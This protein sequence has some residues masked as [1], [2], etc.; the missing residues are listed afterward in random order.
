MHRDPT[1]ARIGDT[2]VHYRRVLA[3]ALAALRGSGALAPP[4]PLSRG[5]WS[6]LVSGARASRLPLPA[7][8]DPPACTHCSLWALFRPRRLM[9]DALR[10][11]PVAV[12]APL[13]CLKARA[14]PRDRAPPVW[15]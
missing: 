1:P 12:S 11:T 7:R 6:S 14:R 4:R 10:S 15:A 2:Q 5:A 9:R 13:A 3:P 8:Y